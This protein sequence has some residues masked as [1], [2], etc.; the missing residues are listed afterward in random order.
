MTNIEKLQKYAEYKKVN[1]AAIDSELNGH[2]VELA[3]YADFLELTKEE[4][5][6]AFASK[7]HNTSDIFNKE[8]IR[9]TEYVKKKKYGLNWLKVNNE[10]F[11]N[12]K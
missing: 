8:L 5:I 2:C 3:S 12:Q 4:V 10:D 1:F 9:V 6:N 7:E 11:L